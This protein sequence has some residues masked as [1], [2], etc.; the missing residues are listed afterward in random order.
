MKEEYNYK[1]IIQKIINFIRFDDLNKDFLN[2]LRT[3]SILK[4]SRTINDKTYSIYFSFYD[5]D[6][7]RCRIRTSN[8]FKICVK[9]TNIIILEDNH[10]IF[11]GNFYEYEFNDIFLKNTIEWEVIKIDKEKLLMLYLRVNDEDYE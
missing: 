10:L 7:E 11:H 1:E 8:D 9:G 3:S 6:S 2:Y 4:T 5:A